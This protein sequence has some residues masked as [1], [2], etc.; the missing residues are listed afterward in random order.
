MAKR[1]RRVVF[2]GA[3]ASKAKARAKERA[4]AGR[5]ILARLIRGHRRY[6]VLSRRRP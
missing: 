6:L 1:G 2:H 4:G 5:Y 3:F